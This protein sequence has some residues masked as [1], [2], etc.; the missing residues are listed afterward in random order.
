MRLLT[1]GL[2][3]FVILLQKKMRK[4]KAKTVSPEKAKKKTM[5]HK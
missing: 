1:S 3:F 2:T 4:T 5:M